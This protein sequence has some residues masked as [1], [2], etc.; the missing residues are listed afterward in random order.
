VL[1]KWIVSTILGYTQD[2]YRYAL[3]GIAV[4]MIVTPLYLSYPHHDDLTHQKYDVHSVRVPKVL[5][6]DKLG[7]RRSEDLSWRGRLTPAVIAGVAIA[8]SAVSSA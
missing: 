3:L 2:P 8:G 5:S 7:Y 1:K 4:R 6:S